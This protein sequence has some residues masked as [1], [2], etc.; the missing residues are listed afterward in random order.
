MLNLIDDMAGS[1]PARVRLVLSDTP[2]CTGIS[3]ALLRGIEAKVVD[4][5]TFKKNS[6]AFDL[7]LQNQLAH[8]EIDLILLAGFMHILGKNFIM[9][10]KGRILNI[11]PSLLPKY[12]GLNTHQRVI[13]A[14]ENKTGCTVHEVVTDLDSGRIHGQSFVEVLSDETALSLAKRV[15]VQEHLL[16]PKV[17]RNFI[18]E[19]SNRNC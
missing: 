19:F 16:Y 18:R 9:A 13:D 10:W 14:G 17:V 3:K 2:K 12:K 5:Q 4:Y 6:A 11:H 8:H 7:E 15:L 1:H